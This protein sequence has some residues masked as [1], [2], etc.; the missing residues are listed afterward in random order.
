MPSLPDSVTLDVADRIAVVT[1]N[2]PEA[3]N[4]VDASVAQGLSAALDEVEARPDIAAGIITGAGGNFCA[5]MDL[6]AFLRGEVVRLPDRGFAGVT[7]VRSSK[8][9]IA[10][11]EGY[12]LAG[13]FEIALWADLIVATEETK[14]GLPEVK[15]G[16]V[17]NA[18]GL[19]RLPRQMPPRIAAELVLTGDIVP[20]SRL[21]PYGIINRIVPAGEALREA[22]ALASRLVE[23]GPLAIAASKRVM[24]EGMDWTTDEMFDRQFAITRPIF[25]SAD[26][27]EG[28]RAFAEKRQ[29][30]WK[31]E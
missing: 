25:E 15:R 11:L 22:R 3:R 9:W 13:G 6:K 29:P 26:A 14:V 7:Q 12:A 21:Q 23:N 4:T 1:I 2:R 24:Q 28:A 18:G 16:L 17:A 10:A 8:P 19:L 30:V 5:G 31:G 20:A 27:R